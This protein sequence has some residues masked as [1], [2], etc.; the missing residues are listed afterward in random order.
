MSRFSVTPR[1]FGN[2]HAVRPADAAKYHSRTQGAGTR[3]LSHYVSAV[4]HPGVHRRHVRLSISRKP[5]LWLTGWFLIEPSQ[6]AGNS[7]QLRGERSVPSSPFRCIE[8]RLSRLLA[9]PT[10]RSS[11]P[12]DLHAVYHHHRVYGRR[13]HRRCVHISIA[14]QKLQGGVTDVPLPSCPVALFTKDWKPSHSS[15]SSRSP[16]EGWTP[17]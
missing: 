12:F 3:R 4:V 15:G 6:W 17:R 10:S 13:C 5:G 7:H 2:T 16:G 11:R 14:S 1:S 8:L 9:Q